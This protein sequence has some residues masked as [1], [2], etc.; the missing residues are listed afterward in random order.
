MKKGRKREARHGEE[1]KPWRR[2][3]PLVFFSALVSSAER[4]SFSV[5]LVKRFQHIESY[6]PEPRKGAKRAVIRV[7]NER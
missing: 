7:E 5:P 6:A 2:E 4:R 1:N 3:L